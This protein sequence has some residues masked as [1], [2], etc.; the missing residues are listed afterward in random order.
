MKMGASET[1]VNMDFS[2][3]FFSS[4]QICICNDCMCIYKLAAMPWKYSSEHF[5]YILCASLNR[6]SIRALHSLRLV[7]PPKYHYSSIHRCCSWPSHLAPVAVTV[8]ATRSVANIIMKHFIFGRIKLGQ[9]L[10][11]GRLPFSNSIQ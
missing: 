11:N 9:L 10:F 2:I 4:F 8:A 1:R 3:V 5:A 6:P 7:W